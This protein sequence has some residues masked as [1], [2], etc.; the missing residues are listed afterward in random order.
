MRSTTTGY[1][2]PA[3]EVGQRLAK[4]MLVGEVQDAFG[5][6]LE[7][8]RAPM[9]GVVIFLVSSLAMNAGDPLLALAG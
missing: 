1:W 5:T 7:E 8:P 4:G 3:V 9:D 6:V 2:H